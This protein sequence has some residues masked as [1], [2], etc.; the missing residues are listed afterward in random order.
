MDAIYKIREIVKESNLSKDVD[1]KIEYE[2]GRI[3]FE[4]L[5]INK[6]LSGIE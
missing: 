1:S 6:E 2:L 4:V 3:K 5:E